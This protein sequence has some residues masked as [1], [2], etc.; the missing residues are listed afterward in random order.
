[1]GNQSKQ[2]QQQKTQPRVQK[3]ASVPPHDEMQEQDE[4]KRRAKEELGLAPSKPSVER[5]KSRH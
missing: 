4:R 2:A 5:N 3:G 1:M